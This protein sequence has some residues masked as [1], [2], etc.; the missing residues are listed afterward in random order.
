MDKMRYYHDKDPVRYKGKL[1]FFLAGLAVPAHGNDDEGYYTHIDEGHA[2]EMQLEK[3]PL[4]ATD[5][6][7]DWPV[8]S[9]EMTALEHDGIEDYGDGMDEEE[10]GESRTI[11]IAREF[12][13]R[14]NVTE[15][16]RYALPV[17]N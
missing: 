5:D 16:R 17:Y 14:L 3:F 13:G 6:A 2:A 1:V 10:F 8:T 4:P 11:L 9:N 12:T 15:R 7:E